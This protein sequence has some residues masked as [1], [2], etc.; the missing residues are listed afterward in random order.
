MPHKY[1]MQYGFVK[2]LRKHQESQ[3]ELIYMTWANKIRHFSNYTTCRLEGGHRTVKRFL[4][5]AQGDLLSVVEL[6]HQYIDTE[7]HELKA[8]LA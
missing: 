3:K 2:Y 6:L 4:C 8:L 1:R 7:I 5:S